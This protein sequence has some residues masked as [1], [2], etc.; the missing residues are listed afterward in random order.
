MTLNRPLHLPKPQLSYPKNWAPN[1]QRELSTCK[2]TVQTNQDMWA[3]GGRLLLD[4]VL[5]ALHMLALLTPSLPCLP[6][7]LG[8]EP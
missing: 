8:P 1:C 3:G 4:Q 7:S 6:S 2:V 5:C